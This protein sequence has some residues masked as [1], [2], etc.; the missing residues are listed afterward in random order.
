MAFLN[1]FSVLLI[2]YSLIF[3]L[4]CYNRLGFLQRCGIEV[5]LFQIKWFTQRFNRLFLRCGNWHRKAI[6]VW[7][8]IGAFFSVMLILPAML[9]LVRTLISNMVQ[10]TT[11][12]CL[13]NPNLALLANK[14]KP[15]LT[16][17]CEIQPHVYNDHI[18]IFEF[19]DFSTQR[20][21]E[22]QPPVYNDCFLCLS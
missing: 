21:C 1:F 10:F 20:T 19:D 13:P 12:R 11:S 6:V 16:T 22:E 17:T 8:S 7:F 5:S 9:L 18:K 4:K 15:V 2:F 14:V 3:V